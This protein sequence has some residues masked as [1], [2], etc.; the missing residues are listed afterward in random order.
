MTA[1]D[2]DAAINARLAASGLDVPEDL[3]VGVLAGCRALMRMVVLLRTVPLSHEDE[4]ASV[5]RVWDGRDG[6]AA[7]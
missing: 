2:D 4:P 1:P 6:D 7:A 3:R 5:F